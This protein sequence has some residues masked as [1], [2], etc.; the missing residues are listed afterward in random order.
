MG[1]GECDVVCCH[2]LTN[3]IKIK[4]AKTCL[5]FH[6]LFNGGGFVNLN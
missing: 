4:P 2:P 6:L 1:G 3:V 5:L